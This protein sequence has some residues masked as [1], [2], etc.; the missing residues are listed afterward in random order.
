MI[1]GRGRS[2]SHLVGDNGGVVGGNGI[3][4]G[5]K[6]VAVGEKGMVAA[7]RVCLLFADSLISSAAFGWVPQANPI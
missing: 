4:V 1:N 2:A 6:G 7:P 5:E 3:A